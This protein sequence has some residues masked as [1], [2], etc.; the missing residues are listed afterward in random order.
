M[1]AL[2]DP[3][4][5]EPLSAAPWNE[6]RAREWIARIAD[7][8]IACYS[9]QRLWPP[10]PLDLDGAPARG[11]FTSM[12]DGAA[13]VIW[14]LDALA[15]NGYARSRDWTA[16]MPPLIERNRCE[17]EHSRWGSDSL[18]IGQGGLALLDYRLSPDAMRADRVAQCVS[19]NA[20]HPSNELM[21]GAP[22]TLVAALAMHEATR[23]PRWVDAFAAGAA[24]L[25]V[26]FEYDPRLGC[27]TWMQPIYGVRYLGAA[28][29]FA[30]NAGVI[31]R[32][33]H[34]LD[35][36]ARR[37]WSQALVQT[38]QRTALRDGALA[39]WPAVAESSRQSSPTLVQWCHGAPGMIACV[40]RL[41]EPDLDALLVAAGELIFVAGPLRKGASLCH[42]TAGNGFAFLKLH[43]RSGDA[44]W[45]ERARA[46]A[47]H[48]I[49]QSDRHAEQY[50]RR[51]H[52]L[53][54][55][56]PGVALY[57]A[58]CIGGG[59][60]LPLVDAEPS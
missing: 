6:A 27:R 36:E 52:S 39:N 4:R 24:A 25:D 58:A 28:H 15:R 55:G 45:L 46:F 26:A 14:A 57:V 47:M 16:V 2:F 53:W 22:G 21:W 12:Y 40:A 8:A 60:A 11:P 35:D 54:T 59:D 34:L 31:A 17:L 43:R 44:R 33:L 13:G 18:L 29:G 42:G 10:H 23:E 37:R 19:R 20:S 51:R 3:A 50:G 38:V 48:A 30:G 5:H 32:G 9:G 56:D 1:T 49:A 7:D 41:P